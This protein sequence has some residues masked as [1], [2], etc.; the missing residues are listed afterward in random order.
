MRRCVCFSA[1]LS[2]RSALS[3]P[4]RVQSLFSMSVSLVLPANR[5]VSTTL[6]DSTYM[7]SY[8]IFVFFLTYFNL[9]K[10]LGSSSSLELTQT[11]SFLCQSEKEVTQSC[12]ALCNRKWTVALQAPPFMRFF[13]ARILEW[14][15]ISFS[16]GSSQPRD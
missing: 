13:Q 3:F 14:V 10:A 9:C 2:I 7:C 16:R 8:T 4:R 11:R 12:P 15:A 6:P 1:T 5:F